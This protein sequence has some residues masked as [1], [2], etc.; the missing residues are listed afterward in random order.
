MKGFKIVKRSKGQTDSRESSEK[1]RTMNVNSI[2]VAKSMHI[3]CKEYE[4]AECIIVAS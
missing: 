2:E 4:L 3:A 1:R